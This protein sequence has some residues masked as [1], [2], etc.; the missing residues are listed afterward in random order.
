[1]TKKFWVGLALVLIVPGLMLA[2]SCAK[3]KIESEPGV[4]TI[5]EE[6]VTEGITADDERARRR[7][8]EEQRI[9]EERLREEAK[10]RRERAELEEFQNKHIY[11]EFDKS[12]LLPE[13]KEI[14]RHKAKWL[15][16]HPDVS[17]IIEGHCDERGTSEYNMALGDRRAQSAKSYL[18]DLGIGSIRLMT[19]SYGE[20]RPLDPSH[21]ERAWGKN[22]R[23]QFVIE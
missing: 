16:A 18:V 4:V 8:L 19:I 3:K 11:F 15:M 20:E 21:N 1:M 14:L 7:A 6:P 13:S 9:R 17:V 23:D 22:R 5:E 12:R 10:T 2:T